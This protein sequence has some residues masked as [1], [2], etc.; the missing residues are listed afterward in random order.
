MAEKKKGTGRTVSPMKPG[1]LVH[2]VTLMVLAMP[3]VHAFEEM[4]VE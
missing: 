1:S 4:A 3:T 2:V